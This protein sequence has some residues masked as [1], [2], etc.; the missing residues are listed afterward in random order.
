MSYLGLDLDD[1]CRELGS[2][3]KNNYGSFNLEV[4][5]DNFESAK[6]SI[7]ETFKDIIEQNKEIVLNELKEYLKEA[8]EDE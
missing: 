6:E 4:I 8:E 3:I 2:L 1:L 5:E 7:L